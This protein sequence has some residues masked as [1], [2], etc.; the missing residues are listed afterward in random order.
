VHV[1]G[2]NIERPVAAGQTVEFTFV[3]KDP[4]VYEVETHESGLSL[5]KIEA[6]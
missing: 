2:V 1:H 5:L 4:G 3:V 6:R